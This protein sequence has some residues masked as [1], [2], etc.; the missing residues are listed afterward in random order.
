MQRQALTVP[1]LLELV[2]ADILVPE[3]HTPAATTNSKASTGALSTAKRTLYSRGHDKV[4][5][6]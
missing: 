4:S 5:T 1:D 6:L 2:A 3:E